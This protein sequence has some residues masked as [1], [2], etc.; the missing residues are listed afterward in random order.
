[1]DFLKDI[2]FPSLIAK[3]QNDRM[4]IRLMALS[5]INN[6]GNPTQTAKYLHVSR[7]MANEWVKR[8]NEKGID[9]L[10]EKPRSGRP[11]A[12]STEQ[13]EK[14][15]EYVVSH[16][17]KPDGGRLKVTLVIAYIEQEFGVSYSLTNIYCLLH[18]LNFSWSTSRSK[19]PKQSQDAQE[20]FKNTQYSK[21]KTQN[22]KLKRS[23]RSR[24]YRLK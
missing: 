24:S 20:D 21:L 13:L 1:M 16:A 18:R 15:K 9:G 5:H 12:L 23:M 17:I 2:D 7:R 4:R 14:L 8:F 19:H 11:R 3:E 22:S 6:G 10:I